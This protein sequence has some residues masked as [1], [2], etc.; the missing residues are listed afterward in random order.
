VPRI[1]RKERQQESLSF[2]KLRI[3]MWELQRQQQQLRA[4]SFPDSVHLSLD[5]EVN[6]GKFLERKLSCL[7]D[8]FLA[9]KLF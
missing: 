9:G 3:I 7:I 6:Q 4:E 8:K 1:K 2:S 5:K